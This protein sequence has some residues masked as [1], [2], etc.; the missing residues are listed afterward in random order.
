MCE[1]V[2][3]RSADVF[4]PQTGR[5]SVQAQPPY[6]KGIE[7]QW[8]VDLGDMQALSRDMGHNFKIPVKDIFRKRTWAIRIK[9]KSWKE[10]LTAFQQ[11]FKVSHPRKP[12]SLQTDRGKEF[13]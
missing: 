13:L 12:A 9:N 3:V 1:A 5:M 2:A 10:V 11:L 4:P 7:A 6:V 8:Q